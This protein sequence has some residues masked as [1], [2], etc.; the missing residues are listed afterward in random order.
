MQEIRIDQSVFESDEHWAK[1]TRAL[2]VERGW[3][4]LHMIGSPGSG[5]T[6]LLEQV[7]PRL[8]RPSAVITGDVEGE[9]DAL[10]LC[11]AGINAV[12]LNTHGAC[13]L[14]AD[15][16][17]PILEGLKAPSGSLIFIENIGN[18]ICPA[19]FPLGE[20]QTIAILCATEG[21]EKPI[22]YPRLFKKADCVL[23]T[24]SALGALC[25]FDMAQARENIHTQ[26][27]Q[28]DIFEISALEGIGLDAFAQYLDQL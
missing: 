13:H 2:A 12:Q 18:L 6:T 8:K 3:I 10:R 20:N 7:L 17:Y 28:A 19:G 24:K 26:R 27:P 14:S 16:L 9:Y 23:I 1:R 11:K 5:K 22:K 25:Y 15:L 4:M 21:A